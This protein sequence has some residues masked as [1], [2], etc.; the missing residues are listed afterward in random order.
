[1]DEYPLDCHRLRVSDRVVFDG[2]VRVLVFGLNLTN[3]NLIV[4][5]CIFKTPAVT[6]LRREEGC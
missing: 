5:G 4:D 1:M 6:K 2:L 3:L